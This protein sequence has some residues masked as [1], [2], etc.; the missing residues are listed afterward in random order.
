MPDHVLW[1]QMPDFPDL[2]ALNA[3]LEQHCQDL[4]RETPHGTLPGTIA[5]VWADERAALMTL[6]AAFDGF[7]EQSKRVSPTCLITFERN[8]YSVPAS[9]AN[10]P[11]SLRIYPERLVVAAEGN[12]L[13]EHPRIIER[14]PRQTTA[15]DLRLAAL[16]CCH[17]TQA[18]C[19]AQWRTL[20]GITVGL[21]TAAGPDAPPPRR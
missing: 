7:V 18:W 15:N 10:R 8:R 19:S 5:D 13:C 21:S 16:S 20:P 4:W 2:P 14:K 6:P 12:I 11:V 17:P 9:F 1:Q 3:W